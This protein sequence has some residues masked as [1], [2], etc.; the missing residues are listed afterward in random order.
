MVKCN[1]CEFELDE[2]DK[3]TLT[4]KVKGSIVLCR[5]CATNFVVN[6]KENR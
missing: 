3:I 6:K 1:F 4:N 2:E 5:E